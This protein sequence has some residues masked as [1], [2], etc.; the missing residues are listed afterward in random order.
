MYKYARRLP[1]IW[2][3]VFVRFSFIFG[4]I[5]SNVGVAALTIQLVPQILVTNF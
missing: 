5:F 1:V 2:Q 3:H 4:F